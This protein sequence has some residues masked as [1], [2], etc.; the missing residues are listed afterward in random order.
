MRRFQANGVQGQRCRGA[1][2][3]ATSKP[4]QNFSDWS[5]KK[6]YGSREKWGWGVLGDKL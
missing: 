4:V 1:E 2:K 6:I 3:A 5:Q